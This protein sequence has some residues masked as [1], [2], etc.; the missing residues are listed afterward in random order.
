MCKF[1]HEELQAF[2]CPLALRYVYNAS[3]PHLFFSQRDFAE[4]DLDIDDLA[5]LAP[6]VPPDGTHTSGN[7][8]TVQDGAAMAVIVSERKHRELGAPPGL[9]LVA[10]ANEGV[11]PGDDARAPVAAL[12]KLLKASNGSL[13]GR[14]GLV[15]V[16]EA[17]AAQA[18][19]LRNTFE[20][21]D[22]E[23]NPDGGA[24][25]RGYP[26]GASSAV[27]VVRLF[28]RLVRA[29]IRPKQPFGAVT[30]VPLGASA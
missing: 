4:R 9:R 12:E 2:F 17:S 14:L 3:E 24:I 6:L 16:S 19:A 25:A 1:V 15:E 5:A 30:Q 22:G 10:S 13:A 20:L 23:L 29:A 21:D 28:T 11:G 26:L 27:S 8:S 18:L 7:T